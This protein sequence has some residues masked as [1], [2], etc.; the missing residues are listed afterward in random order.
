MYDAFADRYASY[1][2]DSPFNAYYD[3][4]AVLELVGEVT[5][6]QVLDAGCGPGL[7]TA[8]LVA[9]GADVVAFDESAEMVRLAQTRLR[10]T[11]D[12]R[13]ASLA[14]PLEW[15]VDESFDVIVMALVLH[16]LDDRAA[17]LRELHR[18]LRPGG[19]LVLSVH[20]PTSDLLVHGGSYFTTEVVEETWQDEWHVRFWRLP[21]GQWCDEFAQAGFVIERL[22]EPRPLP[23][24]AQHYPDDY[25]LLSTEPAF[26]AFRLAKAGHA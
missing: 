7:S 26:I 21:L 25:A 1:I 2:E 10:G 22:V 20:H 19:R 15:L 9:G 16:Y 17:A 13:R 14:E 3:R 12:V 6:K 4:P 18:V 11:A 23:E 8:E 24:M 5:G